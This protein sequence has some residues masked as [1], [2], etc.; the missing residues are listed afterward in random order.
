VVIAGV[1]AFIYIAVSG[2]RSPAFV[3]ILKDTLMVLAVVAVGIAV[4]MAT[5]GPSA[6]TAPVAITPAMST[7]HGSEMTFAITTIIFQALVFYLGL[8]SSYILPAKSERA[9]KGSTVWMPLYML[10]YPLLVLVSYYG[11]Q[12]HPNIKNPNTIFMVTTRGLLPDWLIGVVA[13]GAALSGLLVLAATALSIGGLITRNLVPG[14]PANA[15]RRWATVG[16]AIFLVLGALLT[17]FA[18]SL[19]LTVLNLFYGLIAQ[20][21]PA[22]LAVMFSRRTNAHSIAVGMAVGVGLSIVL[23]LQGPSVIGGINSG[24]VSTGVNALIVIVWRILAP[25]P[26]REPVAR[27]IRAKVPTPSVPSAS[28]R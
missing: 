26:E 24:V 18:S 21:V 9:I 17:V 16:V 20:V 12:A 19:M 2:I 6:S 3:S 11:L 22:F 1:L 10:I 15:Q 8:G 14:V 5:H 13:G 28:V 4:L 27:K 23:Y 7:I 25:G